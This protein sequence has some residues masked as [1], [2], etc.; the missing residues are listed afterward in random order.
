M[1]ILAQSGAERRYRMKSGPYSSH[2]LLLSHFPDTTTGRRVLDVGS[3]AGYVAEILATRGYS[4]R[5]VDRPGTPHPTTVEFSGTDLDEG[6][7]PVGTGFDYIICADVL[8]HLRRPL[9][10]LEDCR[11]RI[12]P[13]G[14]LVASL[15]NSGHWYFRWNVLIGRFPQDDNGLFDRTH[16][17]FYTWDGWVALFKNAGFSIQSVSCSAVP[18]ELALPAWKDTALIRCLSRLSFLCS[19]VWKALF[20]YQFIVTAR[21]ENSR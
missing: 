11:T 7:G 20:A 9:E 3:A 21:V 18:F 8:E 17:H 16:I 12:A 4:V 15:P 5:C 14:T 2:T 6:L 1:R 13:G 10:L 19:R